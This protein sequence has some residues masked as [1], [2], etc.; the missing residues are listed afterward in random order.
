MG[1]AAKSIN[2]NNVFE[3][4]YH[5]LILSIKIIDVYFFKKN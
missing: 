1:S 2:L 4:N 5:Q 3:K